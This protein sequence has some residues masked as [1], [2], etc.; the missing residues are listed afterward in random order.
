VGTFSYPPGTQLERLTPPHCIRCVGALNLIE[1]SE[2][3]APVMALPKV[4]SRVQLHNKKTNCARNNKKQAQKL[5]PTPTNNIAH[6]QE[7]NI[8]KRGPQQSS[9]INCGM[10]TLTSPVYTFSIDSDDPIYEHSSSVER[11]AS[12]YFFHKHVS[13]TEEQNFSGAFKS[14]LR[15][16]MEAATGC[17]IENSED[18]CDPS[19]SLLG[20]SSIYVPKGEGLDTRL[21]RAVDEISDSLPDEVGAITLHVAKKKSEPKIP[22]EVQGEQTDE[23]ERQPLQRANVVESSDSF[24]APLSTSDFEELDLTPRQEQEQRQIEIVEDAPTAVWWQQKLVSLFAGRKTRKV[25]NDSA[26]SSWLVME[27]LVSQI[28]DGSQCKNVPDAHANKKRNS[29]SA[30]SSPSRDEPVSQIAGNGNQNKTPDAQAQKKRDNSS[31]TTRPTR[32]EPVSQEAVSKKR[33]DSAQAREPSQPPSSD[34]ISQ[35]CKVTD[36]KDSAPRPP[37]LLLPHVIPPVRITTVPQFF[38]T[39]FVEVPAAPETRYT[40]Y[41]KVEPDKFEPEV[42]QRGSNAHSSSPD[43]LQFQRNNSAG[44]LLDRNGDTWAVW[45]ER[46]AEHPEEM[47]FAKRPVHTSDSELSKLN[48]KGGGTRPRAGTAKG[49]LELIG[50]QYPYNQ[51]MCW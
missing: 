46:N 45:N 8:A 5:E 37:Q 48:G 25:R 13:S 22:P 14:E 38:R 33:K 21:E 31:T 29:S 44:N 6:S 35:S 10:H 26:T 20:L 16:A 24:Q 2:L 40:G 19:D 7:D 9:T 12:P 27:D 30:S 34:K 51:G 11:E 23:E 28:S 32:H 50:D 3:L 17:A 36:H 47:V 42:I 4:K 39:K 41:A 18:E 1:H 49:F 15:A 43:G